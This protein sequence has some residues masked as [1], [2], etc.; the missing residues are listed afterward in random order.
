MKTKKDPY[1]VLGVKRTATKEELKR[2]RRKKAST[3]H[4]DKG[5]S[6]EGFVQINAAFAL[7]MDE[8]ARAHY[9]AT[10]NWEEAVEYERVKAATIAEVVISVIQQ[11]DP[12]TSDVRMYAL[13]LID[14][15]L[16]EFGKKQKEAQVQIDRLQQAHDRFTMGGF[17]LAKTAM[18]AKINEWQGV[19][20]K[21][22]GDVKVFT[23]I[24]EIMQDSTYQFDAPVQVSQTG[25]AVRFA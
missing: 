17:L 7:L 6:H 16:A 18:M 13:K 12:S 1:Q 24:R 4:P 5:G 8:D 20:A 25:W 23:D 22:N 11:A 10:G 9:D 15:K 3:D 19:V 21:I 14:Y 2:A